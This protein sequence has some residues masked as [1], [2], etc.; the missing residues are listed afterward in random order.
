M[1]DELEDVE[2]KKRI[3]LRTLSLIVAAIVVI[4][5]MA[6]YSAQTRN[7]DQGRNVSLSDIS[8]KGGRFFANITNIGVTE[9]DVESVQISDGTLR[10]WNLPKGIEPGDTES[11]SCIASGIKDGASYMIIFTLKDVESDSNY[12]SSASVTAKS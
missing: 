3:N 7:S 12:R 5:L 6:F 4:A 9:F 11:M 2:P 10:C 1:E 8:L